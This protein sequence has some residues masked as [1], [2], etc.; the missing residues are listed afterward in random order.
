ML[1]IPIIFREFREGSR[2]KRTFVLRGVFG[3]M[4]L[5]VTLLFLL[6]MRLGGESAAG[7]YLLKTLAWMIFTTLFVLAPA[8]T[9]S[10]ITDERKAGTLDLLFLT[11]L[12]SADVVLG[13]FASSAMSV[14]L[15]FLSSLPFLFLPVLMGGVGWDQ[16][17]AVIWSVAS[18]ILLTLSFGM[19]CSAM[20]RTTAR[21][22]LVAYFGLI[23]YNAL[24]VGLPFFNTILRAFGKADYAVAL[25]DSLR[26][27]SPMAGLLT[28]MPRDAWISMA[29]SGGIAA[30][31]LACSIWRLPRLLHAAQAEGGRRTRRT[32]AS[33]PVATRPRSRRGLDRSPLLWLDYGRR[34]SWLKQLAV[35]AVIISAV[36]IIGV[37][38]KNDG[39]FEGGFR[40]S[41][42][43]LG[44]MV[45]FG[46]KILILVHVA[47]A[48][49]VEKEDGSLELLLITP[50]T[51][52]QIV[53]GKIMTV[54]ARYGL[55]YG[56]AC[57]VQYTEL[58]RG[59]GMAMGH[60]GYAVLN[61]AATQ[62]SGL[63]YVILIGLL[64]SVWSRTVTQ[65]IVLTIVVAVMA[66]WVLTLIGSIAI[67]I[68]G[69]FAMASAF[70]GAGWPMF[71]LKAVL[72]TGIAA[73][74]YAVLVKN[75]RW[76]AMR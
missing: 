21:A 58:A 46:A 63:A 27:I 65:A 57:A 70:R 3:G 67:G 71:L 2:R 62:V 8:L 41:L 28:G 26:T 64:I 32:R 52:R 66:N 44:W 30:L 13:K 20:V 19:F 75:L 7:Y 72:E 61:Q 47:R 10:S 18:L 6:M 74:A 69:I 49:A 4:L 31:L 16:T 43:A 56:A 50:F 48:F 23:A 25:F 39:I 1:S 14:L 36:A 15:L 60:Q 24:L 68:M 5:L 40:Y 12:N 45:A 73:A 53:H 51:N 22:V 76:F 9:C 33:K 37:Y 55:L 34:H 54:L 35:F 59:F 42:H 29:W 38:L 11:H 17:R